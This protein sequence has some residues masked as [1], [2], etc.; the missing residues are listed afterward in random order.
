VRTLFGYH[1]KLKQRPFIYIPIVECKE[2]AAELNN[3]ANRR[4]ATPGAAVQDGDPGTKF[5]E[6]DPKNKW[7]EKVDCV[8]GLY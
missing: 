4:A 8:E 1:K 6:I 5:P 3:R 2:W 7:D